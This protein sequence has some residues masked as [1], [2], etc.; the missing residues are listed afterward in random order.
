MSE[1]RDPNEAKRSFD[2]YYSQQT[3][4]DY[5]SEM[6]RLGYQ[7]AEQA[8]PYGVAVAEALSELNPGWPIRMLDVG[9]SYGIGSAFV[10]YGCTFEELASFFSSRAPQDY[11]A[12]TN[13]TRTWL[14]VVPPQVD[15][16]VVGLD[17]SG[18]AVQ[19]S[20]D[21]GLLD[22]GIVKNLEEEELLDDEVAWIAGCN[23]LIC[24]GAI[25]YVGE[26]T[27]DKIL[28][29]LGSTRTDNTGPAALM[30]VL[31]MFDISDVEPSFNKAGLEVRK[32]PGVRLPQRGFADEEEMEGVLKVLADKG[33][34]AE[35]WE[36]LGAY[37]A[38][39]Y[40]AAAPGVVGQLVRRLSE[41]EDGG[42]L[43]TSHV[44]VA[45][46]KQPSG[47]TLPVE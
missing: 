33:I 16:G 21:S 11:R 26:V 17:V 47:L 32:V 38:D 7:I 46:A 34:D 20:V 36:S 14:N 44:A 6:S 40:V 35:G 30:T 31:R 8:R 37:Y 9:C 2:H 1:N 39:L 12:C 25:G 45:A 13:A 27:F 18:P 22:C 15:M 19:F 43:F 24:T 4:H 10:K 41:T 29:H 3:P 23:L 42:P 28:R 5:L